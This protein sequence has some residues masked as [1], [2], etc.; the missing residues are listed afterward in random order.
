MSFLLQNLRW[1]NGPALFRGDLRIA[2][3]KILATG[4]H[5][6]PQKKETVIAFDN[7]F[8]YPGLINAHDHL[9]MNL[10]PNLGHPPYGNFTEWAKE[11]YQ[12][13]ESPVREIE[14]LPLKDRLLWGG[15]KNLIAGVTTVIHHNPFHGSLKSSG[16][17][18]K[19]LSSYAWAHSLEFEKTVKQKFPKFSKKPFMIHAAE[20]TDDF[21][22]REIQ[23]LAELGVL[24]ANTVLIHAIGL[25]EKARQDIQSAGASVVWCPSSNLF[26]FGRTAEISAIK[27]RIKVALGSDSTMTGKA[28][29]FEEMQAALRTGQVTAQEIVDRVTRVPEQIFRLPV[30]RLEP[31][32]IADLLILPA[33]RED[34]AENLVMQDSEN[35][36]AVFVNGEF[37]F[38]DRVYAQLFNLQESSIR[39]GQQTKWISVDI[40]SL[41]TRLSAN[42]GGVF[43][44]K[45]PLWDLLK[46]TLP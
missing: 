39:V 13:T 16:F 1:L 27:T 40:K 42:T 44:S 8:L 7:H 12:P 18:V 17:P 46:H 10:Y 21:A 22:H 14:A 25:T 33:N 37:R 30:R 32:G 3:G 23:R 5:L 20:G 19:V 45:N 15:V 36:T 6:V 31:G 2:N 9:E 28:T 35:T 11:I 34:Y 4:A 26:M 43:F 41:M 29:F 24:K 38:G